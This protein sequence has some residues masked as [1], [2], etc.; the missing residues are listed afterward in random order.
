[1]SMKNGFGIFPFLCCFIMVGELLIINDTHAF[2]FEAGDK[3]VLQNT[4]SGRYV[5][6]Q[7]I[8]DPNEDPPRI[9]DGT[10]G[11]FLEGPVMGKG[12]IYTWYEVEWET[13][14][15]KL[16]GYTADALDDCS[17]IAPAEE[18]DKRDAIVAKLFGFDVDVV[19]KVTKHEYNGYGCNPNWKKNGKPVYKYG[20]HAGWDVKTWDNSNGK[21]FYSLTSGYVTIAGFTDKN[22]NRIKDEDEEDDFHTIGVYDPDKKKTTL[23]LHADEV[24]PC[25]KE[26]LF[27][28]KGEPLGIQGDKGSPGAIH[29]HIEVQPDRKWVSAEGNEDPKRETEDPIDYLY[30]QV[31]N[32]DCD[33][34]EQQ[35]KRDTSVCSKDVNWDCSVDWKD[36][37]LVWEHIGKSAIDFPQYDV[38]NDRK[39]NWN[40]VLDVFKE[41]G[42]RDAPQATANNSS[43]FTPNKTALL[44]NYPNPFNP[45]T[46]MPYQ[47]AKASDVTVT[48]Y[49][50]DGIVVRTLSL[51][52]QPIGIYQDKGRAAYWDGKN[53][54]GESV[55]S[56]VYFYTLIAGD[57][58]ATRKMLIRK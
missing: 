31:T 49:A 24:L 58:T 7:P 56:G 51:G 46:W 41:F 57:F 11:T 50:V 2:E 14:H 33:A 48:I 52:H 16:K 37:W 21:V 40:D 43:R 20:G 38:N 13:P 30:K 27:I 12:N 42:G 19:D 3:V 17:Y 15:G 5:R 25:I 26:G 47:L 34:A 54:L 55:A 36:L 45:E 4:F 28:K 18:A 44:A 9:L 22:E 39:I 6:N 23:Y 10:R 32:I 53:A 8:L 35:I 1:M 29:V